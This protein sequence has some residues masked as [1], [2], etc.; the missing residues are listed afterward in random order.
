M[1]IDPNYIMLI[2]Y[3][4]AR[5]SNS[6]VLDFQ[7][8]EKLTDFKSSGRKSVTYVS[9]S[10]VGHSRIRQSVSGNSL[11]ELVSKIKK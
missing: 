9:Y 7:E 10:T 5:L 6:Q 2:P 1:K 8:Y 11:L 3:T 4:D